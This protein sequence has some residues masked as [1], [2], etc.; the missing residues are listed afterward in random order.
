MS[1]ARESDMRLA[2]LL[3]YGCLLSILSTGHLRAE[4][5]AQWHA[6]C[7]FSGNHFAFDFH[8]KSG[9]TEEDDMLV[10]LR[11]LDREPITVPIS[12]GWFR[13]SE[14][15][16]DRKSV[17]NGVGAFSIGTDLI[18][19]LIN[20]NSRPD[21]DHIVAVLIDVRTG[22]ILSTLEDI[23]EIVDDHPTVVLTRDGIRILVY[24][25]WTQSWNGG[26]FGIPGWKDL[27]IHGGK[28]SMQW[29]VNE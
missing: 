9:Y 17:C 13:S 24:Q 6:E 22:N 12:P 25:R 11:W 5:L 2:R 20:R 3:A 18:L 7:S 1:F 28:L 29:E 15:A 23:G 27:S 19:A 21:S 8:S 16:T 10:T 4:E 14:F 26:E